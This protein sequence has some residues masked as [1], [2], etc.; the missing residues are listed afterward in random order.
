MPLADM[1]TLRRSIGLVAALFGA[2][3][4]AGCSSSSDAPM[5]ATDAANFAGKKGAPMSDAK[6]QAISDF[7]ANFKKLHPDTAGPGG[8][9]N[10]P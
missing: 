1:K 6:K 4:G 9:P 5:P 3:A 7:Q 8:P 2:L 10:K